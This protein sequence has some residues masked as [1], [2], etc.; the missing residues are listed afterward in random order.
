MRSLESSTASNSPR[1]SPNRLPPASSASVS[2]LRSRTQASGS[3]PVTSSSHTYGSSIAL[4][5][6]T[7]PSLAAGRTVVAPTRR[8]SAHISTRSASGAGPDQ[9][10]DSGLGL[11]L[12]TRLVLRLGLLGLLIGFLVAATDALVHRRHP[13]DGASHHRRRPGPNLVGV[14]LLHRSGRLG[15]PG[16]DLRGGLGPT[17]GEPAD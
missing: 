6:V 10:R 11:R 9:G 8:R 4:D 14:L 7:E 15:G 1:S 13:A 12:L 17:T 16:T 3:S 5:A 2:A